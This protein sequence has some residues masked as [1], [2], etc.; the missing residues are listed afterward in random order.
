MRSASRTASPEFHGAHEHLPSQQASTTTPVSSRNLRSSGHPAEHVDVEHIDISH[1]TREARAL[2]E[3]DLAH[4]PGSQGSPRLPRSSTRS[5]SLTPSRS[6]ARDT[7]RARR[8][9]STTSRRI[10]N[11]N[12]TEDE[13]SHHTE[14]LLDLPHSEPSTSKIVRGVD[15][16]EPE[17]GNE[18]EAWRENLNPINA[19]LVD[20]EETRE[21]EELELQA[22]GNANTKDDSASDAGSDTSTASD[23]TATPRRFI[24][25]SL[26]RL[27]EGDEDNLDDLFQRALAKAREAEK[28][29]AAGVQDELQAD[30][31]MVGEKAVKER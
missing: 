12:V 23:A 8:G 29:D 28:I 14:L 7:S 27:E 13:D 10:E 16:V 5:A 20:M 3:D 18:V 19:S 17:A 26:S 6:S 21:S 1:L 11:V 9:K 30:V 15:S 24:T 4:I 22:I 2:I 25:S 31:M